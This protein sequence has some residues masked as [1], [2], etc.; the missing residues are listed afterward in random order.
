MSN[1]GLEDRLTVTKQLG[2]INRLF[3]VSHLFCLDQK[4]L[5]YDQPSMLLDQFK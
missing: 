5:C 1:T 3:T 4:Q 2:F